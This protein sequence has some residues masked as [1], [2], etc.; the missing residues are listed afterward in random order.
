LDGESV[1]V[2]MGEQHRGSMGKPHQLRV[3]DCPLCGAPWRGTYKSPWS[4]SGILGGS[5]MA[6][7]EV[8][9]CLRMKILCQ[10]S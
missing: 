4:G 3:A 5:V 7:G 1:Y 8:L 6:E 9:H 10:S 2:A